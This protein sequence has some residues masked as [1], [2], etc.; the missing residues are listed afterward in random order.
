MKS[1]F[2]CSQAD[3]ILVVTTGL[4]SF[5]NY[6][7][8]F[9]LFNTKL[10]EDW[11][12]TMRTDLA[13]AEAMPDEAD[14]DSRK[15]A[16]GVAVSGKAV[17]GRAFWQQMKG[18]IEGAFPENLV[19]I[20]LTAAGQRLYKEASGGSWPATQ[21]LFA[22]ATRFM[23]A[24]VAAL[25]AAGEMPATFPDAFAAAITAF[26]TELSEYE[27]LKTDIMVESQERRAALNDI[28]SRFMKMMTAG[29]KIFKDNPAVYTQFVF[30]D[31]LARVGG[32][33]LAGLDGKVLDD[34]TNLAISGALIKLFNPATPEITYMATAD[35]EGEYVVN[36]PSGTYTIEVMAPGYST[37]TLAGVEVE[38]GT[39]SRF[40][41]KLL[42][43]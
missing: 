5:F 20:K 15:R 4:N 17:A 30:A 41:V 21:Q 26:R 36:S 11:G 31:V 29:Q 9:L 40:N 34:V 43:E 22:A 23:A 35:E 14:G 32:H 38:V 37:Y 42:P 27:S 28:H 6:L 1:N 3:L 33:G 25:T 19:D 10:T 18:Y 12:D 7:A 13:A 39:I 8:E 24:N 2:N 16:K